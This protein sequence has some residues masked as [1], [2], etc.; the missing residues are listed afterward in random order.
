[1]KFKM[2][3]PLLICIFTGLLLKRNNCCPPTKSCSC[4]NLVTSSSETIITRSS[5]DN[6]FMQNFPI[7]TTK[8]PCSKMNCL[9]GY[10]RT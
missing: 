10:Q 3:Y 8:T 4:N 7:T 5:T 2:K 6:W 9:N 1:M